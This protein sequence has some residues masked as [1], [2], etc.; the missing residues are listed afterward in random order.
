MLVCT[1]LHA[2]ALGRRRINRLNGFP[3]GSGRVAGYSRPICELGG[4]ATGACGVGLA[5]DHAMGR[6]LS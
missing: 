5:R 1:R 6:L 2:T 3:V 4:D